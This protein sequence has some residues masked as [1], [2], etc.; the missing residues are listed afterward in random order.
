[1]RIFC[2]YPI[3]RSIGCFLTSP[4]ALSQG[5]GAIAQS[6]SHYYSIISLSLKK[7]TKGKVKKI[8]FFTFILFSLIFSSCKDLEDFPLSQEEISQQGE[9]FGMYILCEG[10]YAQNSSSLGYYNFDSKTFSRDIFLDKNGRKLGDTANDMQQYGSNIYIV[11]NNSG[12]IEVIDAGS[13]QSK[14]KILLRNAK[15]KNRNPRYITFYDGKAYVACF[16]STVCKIDTNTFAVEAVVKAGAYPDGICAANNKLYVSNSGDRNSTAMGNTVSVINISTFTKIKEITVSPNPYKIMPDGQNDVYLAS[17]GSYQGTGP[18][19]FQRIDTQRDEVAQTFNNIEA[20]NFTIHNDTAYIYSY[21]FATQANCIKTFDCRTE[22]IIEDNFIKDGT[23]LQTPYGIAVNPSNS[24]V[25]ITDAGSFTATGDVFCFERN[26]MLK[27]KISNVGLNP[28]AIVFAN[29]QGDYPFTPVVKTN[30]IS[31]VI[32]YHPAPGQFTGEKAYLPTGKTPEMVTYDEVLARISDMLVNS[33]GTISLGGWGGYITLGFDQPIKNVSGSYD[34]KVYG[35]AYYNSQ[36]VGIGGN[37]EPGIVLVSQDVN[38]NGIADD[39]WYELA[40]SEYHNSKTIRD[41][42]ITYYKPNP[43]NGDVMWRD[44]QGETSYIPRNSYHHQ[45]SYYP[46]WENKDELTFRG[47]RLPD[48][49]EFISSNYLLYAYAFGYADNHPNDSEY[50]NFNID[51]AV[52]AAGN[53]VDLNEIHFIRIYSAVNQVNGW[54]GETST[55][56]S[57]VENLHP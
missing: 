32:D 51:W 19:V 35:N 41:Y 42:E 56:V 44:N 53:H 57:G 21:N 43:L 34:F 4:P 28:N 49:G 54:I 24:N 45:S 3:V 36:Y 40:G 50:S 46:L 25:Y 16:D 31:K 1:M 23:T 20:L 52:D 10:L 8:L 12:T 26:G 48:N 30:H 22:K 14:Q 55:E 2:K 18:Y 13:G 39:P 6:I 5:E 15:G 11:V 9:T 29:K 33:S 38:A 47:S 7:E 17:R 37:S 27:F